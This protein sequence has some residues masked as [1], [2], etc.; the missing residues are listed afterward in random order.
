MTRSARVYGSSVGWQDV[1]AQ[2]LRIQQAHQLTPGDEKI[3][4]AL[5]AHGIS[6]D[7]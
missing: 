7:R 1:A 6:V 4:E 5:H 3:R 2:Y